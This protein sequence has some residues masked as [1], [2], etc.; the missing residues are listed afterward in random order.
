MRILYV[1]DDVLDADLLQR[2][3][4]RQTPGL[5][6][7]VVQTLAEARRR[8]EQDATR[9]SLILI[10]L[11]LPDGSGM[12]FLLEIRQKELPL[13]VIMLTGHGDEVAAV[14]ALRAGADD[15]LVKRD[16]YLRRLPKVLEHALGGRLGEGAYQ[17]VSMKMLYVERNA[18]DIDLTRR[19][20]ARHAP[21]I[22]MEAVNTAEEAYRLLSAA[23]TSY[24]VLLLDY[25]LPGLG[26]LELLKDLRQTLQ[27]DLPVVL[28]TGHG[29]EEVAVKALRLGAAEY[30]VKHKGYLFQLPAVV[31]NTYHRRRLVKETAALRESEQ[32]LKKTKNYLESLIQN[33][34][35]P[36]M[37]WSPD[38][39]ITGF[40]RAF[41]VLTGRAKDEV[42]GQNIEILFPEENRAE[43]MQ[44]ISRTIA[45]EVW[46]VKDIAIRHTS[47]RKH[48]VLW[49]SANIY[50]S[51]DKL[52]ATIAQGQ[53]ITERKIA[54]RDLQNA[55]DATIA[56]WGY[57]VDLKDK[58]TGD[59][60][61]RVAE[62]TL[63][64]ALKLGIPTEELPHIRRGVLLHDIGK[65]G[66]P[67]A[68]LF[69][70]DK[71][72]CDEWAMMRQ[73]PTFAYE[74]LSKIAYLHP[75]LDVPYCHHEK[76]DGS[77]YPRGLKGEHIPLAARIF[78]VVDVHDALTSDRPYR[79]AW[80]IEEV[81]QYIKEQSGT[82]FDPQVVDAFMQEMGIQRC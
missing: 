26:A 14:S 50:D 3:L 74:M 49:N 58:D 23:G 40:N 18:E 39:R 6:I 45:G 12:D 22:S 19:H 9:Y 67:D 65:M 60:S 41:E 46:E 17:S 2:E 52:V 73:H 4:A 32:Q 71:L 59:H 13:V 72:T 44:H 66:I 47:G 75:A 7:E 31:E 69:K 61:Q 33:A 57:A 53:D 55:Y 80:K 56:G 24:G 54:E 48:D 35:A 79:S 81:L 70:P 42:I 51:E 36:I 11:K 34:N 63:R 5:A 38:L 43:C 10:D 15:Y 76:W 68:I 30:L 29:D 78:A 37:T 82:H 64:I 25:R 21:H 62:L 1:E 20:I 77:G 27:L 28:I 8:L 16:D